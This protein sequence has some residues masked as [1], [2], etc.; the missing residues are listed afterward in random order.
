MPST[1]SVRET[2]ER[3]GVTA[4][5][6]L[7]W[8]RSGELKALN[9]GRRADAKKPR[10]RI[11]EQALAEFESKRSPA[12]PVRRAKRRKRPAGVIEFYK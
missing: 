1:Y 12:P 9:V 7:V 3:Y 11:T 2:S 10:W 6:V 4:H 8:I 5:T